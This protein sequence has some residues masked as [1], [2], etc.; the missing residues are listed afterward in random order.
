VQLIDFVEFRYLFAKAAQ[1]RE[2][3]P[4][5]NQSRRTITILPRESFLFSAT[6]CRNLLRIADI[7]ALVLA[8]A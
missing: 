2:A 5:R 1:L 4:V 8:I 6:A 7:A 3:A